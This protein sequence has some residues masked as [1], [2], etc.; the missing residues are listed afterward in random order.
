MSSPLNARER[1]T[2]FRRSLPRAPRLTAQRVRPKDR[3]RAILV[4]G[5]EAQWSTLFTSVDTLGNLPQDR[6]K[7]RWTYVGRNYRGT[8]PHAAPTPAESP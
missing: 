6:R 7:D 1:F 5:A 4:G 2:A 3:V 8:S